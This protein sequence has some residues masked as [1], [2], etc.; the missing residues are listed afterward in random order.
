VF[1]RDTAAY[2]RW[3]SVLENCRNDACFVAFKGLA[4]RQLQ[5]RR[6]TRLRSGDGFMVGGACKLKREIVLLEA[7]KLSD[8]AL[9]IGRHRE[10]TYA[11]TTFDRNL[12]L[13]EHF[14]TF[15]PHINLRRFDLTFASFSLRGVQILY[16]DATTRDQLCSPR[17]T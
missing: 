13:T 4:L 8:E 11:R 17:T 6:E 14:S 1:G 5:M 15:F 3:G 16:V 10:S 2:L 7:V 9:R 12:V